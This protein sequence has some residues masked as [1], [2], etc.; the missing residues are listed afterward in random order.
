MKGF[1]Q[2]AFG[3]PII[4][5]V[6]GLLVLLEGI[7]LWRYGSV[8]TVARSLDAAGAPLNIACFVLYIVLAIVLAGSMIRVFQK[9]RTGWMMQ[10]IAALG[11][12]LFCVAQAISMGAGAYGEVTLRE[13]VATPLPA[14]FHGKSLTFENK[15][16]VLE[17]PE[18]VRWHSELTLEKRLEVGD[19]VVHIETIEKDKAIVT[20]YKN[21]G[22][23][24]AYVSYGVL[25][26]GLV[27]WLHRIHLRL[28][29]PQ[30]EKNHKVNCSEC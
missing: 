11:L 20:V 22:T 1:A 26:L 4:A 21:P 12:A 8:P 10:C 16:L 7:H 14:H 18:G 25:L 3:L 17:T 27:L 24:I 30:K 28:R 6:A 5:S 29:L 19:V 2:Q 13:G 9:H 15:E 23:P